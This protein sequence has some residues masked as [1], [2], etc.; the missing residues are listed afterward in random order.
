MP[1]NKIIAQGKKPSPMGEE[2]LP[3]PADQPSARGLTVTSH[4]LTM[5]IKSFCLDFTWRKVEVDPATSAD[6][7]AAPAATNPRRLQPPAMASRE[8]ARRR[9]QLAELLTQRAQPLAGARPLAVGP[10]GPLAV[11]GALIIHKA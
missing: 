10:Q 8:E 3:L 9:Q 5:Q 2:L 11:A 7:V 6:E 1:V 4:S